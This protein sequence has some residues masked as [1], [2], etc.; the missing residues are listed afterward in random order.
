MDLHYINKY[1]VALTA[2]LGL[3]LASCSVNDMPEQND[4]TIK[5]AARVQN[6]PMQAN[7]HGTNV[8]VQ[9]NGKTY[10]YTLTADGS[11]KAQ[12]DGLSWN[13]TDFDVKAWTPA[14]DQSIDLTDQSTDE[15]L[16]ACDLLTANGRA[17]SHFVTLNFKHQMARAKWNIV[18]ID[19]S[20]TEEQ[21]SAVRVY[22]LGYGSVKFNAGTVTPEGNPDQRI[23]ACEG[24]NPNHQGIAHLAPA[25]MW[26]KPLF[27]VEIG[28]DTYVYTPSKANESDLAT[29]AGDLQAGHAK[30]YNIFIASHLMTVT[31]ETTDAEWGNTHES[32]EGDIADARLKADIDAEVSA[33]PDCKVSGING[34]YVADRT[35]GFTI[36]YTENA[37]GGLTWSGTCKMTRS[38]VAAAGSAT[39]HTY[40][41]SDVKSDVKVTYLAGVE[42]GDYV[43]DNGTWGKEEAREDCKTLGR[44]FRV[45][46]NDADDS[47]YGLSKVRGYVA[48]VNAVSG[49]EYKWFTN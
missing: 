12:G 38:E 14:T 16:L 27:R 2:A 41:F 9:A 11:M 47:S 36:T 45:G 28:G 3:G 44:V 25:D 23:A 32:G 7:G 6:K 29:A 18:S 49:A 30:T 39:T 33:L 42:V 26:G 46:L 48:P 37:L 13:G 17:A 1:C 35:E 24:Y 4:S 21:V 15:K 10:S 34:Q 19:E 5:F 22:F 20:Y 8:A 43:Y 40:T 31:T